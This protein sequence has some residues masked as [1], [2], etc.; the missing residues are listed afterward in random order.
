MFIYTITEF[1]SRATQDIDFLM[2]KLSNDIAKVKDIMEEISHV[3]TVNDYITIEML[4]AEMITPDKEYQGESVKF[5]G[6]IKQVKIPFSID[7]GI[8]DVII[9]LQMKG[10]LKMSKQVPSKK[11]KHLMN[12]WRKVSLKLFRNISKRYC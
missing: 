7:I 11:Y 5:I 4:N 3:P 9:K 2:R 1:Q 12:A 10:E 8:D 6:R